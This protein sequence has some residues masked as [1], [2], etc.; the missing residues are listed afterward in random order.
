MLAAWYHRFFCW[1]GW[2]T[3]SWALGEGDTVYLDDSGI[4]DYAECIFWGEKYGD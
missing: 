1:I 4:P 2:H 3:F